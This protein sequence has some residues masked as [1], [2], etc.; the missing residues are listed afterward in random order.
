MVAVVLRRASFAALCFSSLLACS[1]GP[2]NAS[3][4]TNTDC[5]MG[6]RVHPQIG[7]AKLKAL[8][9]GAALASKQLWG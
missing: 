9:E 1:S 7:W 2:H 6:N 8:S 5:G 3:C 4:K